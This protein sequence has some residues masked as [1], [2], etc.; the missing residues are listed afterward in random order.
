MGVTPLRDERWVKFAGRAYHGSREWL[1]RH[2][3]LAAALIVAGIALNVFLEFA[4]EVNNPTLLLIDRLI[5]DLLRPHRSDFLHSVS[6][7]L[8]DLL[9]WPW[10]LFVTAPFFIFLLVTGR[11]RLAKVFV[12]APLMTVLLVQVLKVLTS[13]DRPLTAVIQEIGQSFPSGHAAGATVVY[14]LMGYIAWRYMTDNTVLRVLIGLVTFLL[15]V[16]TGLARIYLEVHYT[17]DVIAGWSA[18]IFILLG[19]LVAVETWPERADEE[20]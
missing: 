14:G 6:L 20:E 9:Y 5:L 19:T 12:I 18:G 11:G 3:W 10:V 13:R 4:E 17:S 8:S 2:R 16:G 7:A 15:I 1:R